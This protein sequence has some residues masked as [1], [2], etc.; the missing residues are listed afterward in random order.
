MKRV[1]PGAAAV[2]LAGVALLLVALTFDAA[3]LFVPAV[4]LVAARRA[5]PRPGSGLRPGRPG[6]APAGRRA[7]GRGASRSRPGSRSAVARRAAGAELRDPLAGA[8]WML[9]CALRRA[10]TGASVRVVAASR[11]RAARRFSRRRCRA[12][13]ARAG[14]VERVECRPAAASCSCCRAPS[15]SP[16]CAEARRRRPA[17]R[18][19]AARREPFAATE[20]DGLRPYRPGTPAS[21]IHWPALARGAGLLERRLRADGDT[22]PLVVLDARGSGAGAELLDAAVRAAASLALEL[23][24]RGGCEL[25]LPGERRSITSGRDLAAWPAAHALLALVEGGAARASAGARAA[26][27][28][29][30]RC[31]TWSPTAR[32]PAPR[33][34]GTAGSVSSLV[35]ARGAR[36]RAGRTTAFEVSGCRGFVLG[37]APAPREPGQRPA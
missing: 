14:P 13:S 9:G 27:A 3:P 7:R 22:R 18:P 31:S 36:R 33:R 34:A 19:T 23:A 5:R 35:A 15:A 17:I 2:A 6:R 26:P 1:A 10:R 37:A 24:R 25:L 28:A 11:A 30:A 16:G 8:R 32:P 12:R 21:R 20:V 4:A 29:S